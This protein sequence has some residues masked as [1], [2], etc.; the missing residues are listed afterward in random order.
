MRMLVGARGRARAARSPPGTD[1][2]SSDDDEDE[3]EM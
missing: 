3:D 2:R 1:L